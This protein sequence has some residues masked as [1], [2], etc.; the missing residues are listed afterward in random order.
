SVIT[1]ATVGLTKSGAGTVQLNVTN[2]Y[3]GNT[4]VE[5]GTLEVTGSLASPNITMSNGATL[6]VDSGASLSSSTN[7]TGNGTLKIF[8][9]NTPTTVATVSGVPVV[10]FNNASQTLNTLN[11]SALINLDGVTNMTQLT[12]NNGGIFAGMFADGQN[13]PGGTDSIIIAGG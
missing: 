5:R 13:L 8:G 4:H 3:G 6:T 9:Q 2:T 10:N 11:G 7:L 12:I 1:G